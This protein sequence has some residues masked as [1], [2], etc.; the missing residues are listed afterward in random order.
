MKKIL[1]LAISFLLLSSVFTVAVSASSINPAGNCNIEFTVK[2]ADPS[3]VIKDGVIG[4]LEYEKCDVTLNDTRTPLLIIYG[5][6]NNTYSMA[7]EM[8]KTMEYYFSWDDV[9]GFNFAVK[10]RPPM[11]TQ[12][13][14]PKTNA[15][16]PEDEFLCN[17]GLAV[18]FEPYV[19]ADACQFYYA[20]SKIKDTGEYLEGHWNQLGTH[21]TF[22]PEPLKD[23]FISFEDDGSVIFEWSVPFDDIVNVEAKP[24]A[25]G[26]KIFLDLSLTAGT[27]TPTS[28]FKEVYGISFGDLGFLGDRNIV[29]GP[30]SATATLSGEMITD[31]VSPFSDVKPKNWFFGSVAYVANEARALMGGVSATKFDPNG[32]MTRGQLVTVLWRNE[33]SKTP[34]TSAVFTDVKKGSYYEK[35]I[36]WAA[37]NGIVNGVGDGKFAPDKP[38]TREQI[39]AIFCRF[40]E[41]KGYDTTGRGKMTAFSDVGKISAWAKDP[42][43]WAVSAGLIK[44]TKVGAK[45]LVDPLGNATRA[46][47]ATII[48]RFIELNK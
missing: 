12:T 18:S 48:M 32:A 24:V 22:D 41:F 14:Y 6:G 43:S 36:S 2:K 38:I 13:I 34:G 35:A 28:L 11:F 25:D 19:T 3:N 46:E 39:A 21:G 4:E 45:M 26:L 40:A 9:H 37:E 17:L 30:R 20:I 31:W 47:V 7:L 27:D 15:K 29:G 23:Y 10:C 44:G 1:C 8:L 5:S 33:G 42:V 16:F